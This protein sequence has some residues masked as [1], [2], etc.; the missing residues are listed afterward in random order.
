[1]AT[2]LSAAA[3]GDSLRDRQLVIEPRLL[4]LR[5][6]VTGPLVAEPPETPPRAQA[7]PFERV[8]LQPLFVT[9]TGVAA[10]AGAEPPGSSSGG[11]VATI[12]AFTPIWIA[13]DLI[14][15]EGLLGCLQRYR[16]TTVDSLVRCP[17]PTPEELAEVLA[18]GTLPLFPAP[19]LLHD[20]DEVVATPE[21]VV[22][23]TAGTL[24][25]AGVEVTV[26]ASDP[27]GAG[28][29]SA[30]CANGFFAGD[31]N[32]PD[33]CIVAVG[34]VSV[35]PLAT[36]LELAE[37]AGVELPPLPN[38]PPAD[39]PDRH[40]AITSMTV[41]R[42]RDDG[43]QVADG[44]LVEHGGRVQAKYG[45]ILLVEVSSPEADLQTYSVPVNDGEAWRTEDE[46]YF[47]DWYRTWG[48]QLAS[49]SDDPDSFNQWTLS[50]GPQDASDRAPGDEAHLFYV[51]RDGRAGVA[52]RWF[53]VELSE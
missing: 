25:G 38:P 27:S 53:T 24:G 44:A 34:R 22:P 6:D 47:G 40:P 12:E 1:M 3:C 28:T 50:A 37:M 42:F 49:T 4:A 8:T 21:L 26:F 45:E 13:C 48:E 9:P 15:G 52:W 23:A 35:G 16:P 2:S 46:R 29:P 18:G 39:E 31:S 5:V 43:V 32:L 11:A 41:T 30:T 20:L 36:L 10:P 51:V 19:C 7:L 33:D 14:P 17:E